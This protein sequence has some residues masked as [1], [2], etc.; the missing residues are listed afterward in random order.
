MLVRECATDHYALPHAFQ[1]QGVSGSCLCG[2]VQDDPL[3]QSLEPE[4]ASMPTRF[5]TERGS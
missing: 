2:R 3:H 5:P 4:K 1:S